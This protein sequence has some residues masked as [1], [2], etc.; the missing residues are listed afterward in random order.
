MAEGSVLS[1]SGLRR[2]NVVLDTDGNAYIPASQRPDGTWRRARRVKDGYIPQEEVPLYQSKG[3]LVVE[4][5]SLDYPQ[6]G[7]PRRFNTIDVAQWSLNLFYL[8]TEAGTEPGVSHNDGVEER[9]LSRTQKKAA[10]RKQRKREKK[11]ADVAFEIEELTTD[12]EHTSLASTVEGSSESRAHS[13]PSL[14]APATQAAGPASTREQDHLRR[15]RALRKKLKQIELLEARIKSGEIVSP[16]R[17][18]AIKISRKQDLIDEI[19]ELT[20]SS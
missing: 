1:A 20:S 4:R 14:G 9:A 8:A 19:L 11:A 2:E 7:T 3:K 10:R 13:Q 6:V 16:D 15:V 12:L 5:H 18:Q 17:D